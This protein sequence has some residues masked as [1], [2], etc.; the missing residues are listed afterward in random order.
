VSR[1]LIS[2]T[3]T[4]AARHPSFSADTRQ[5]HIVHLTSPT[6]DP[7]LAEPA[8]AASS[9]LDGHLSA[10]RRSTEVAA[11]H[12]TLPLSRDTAC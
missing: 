6:C 2:Y 9:T 4:D 12:V 10:A 5:T 1:A 11:G 7:Y 3:Q 8:V